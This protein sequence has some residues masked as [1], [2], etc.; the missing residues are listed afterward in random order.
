MNQSF[1]CAWHT[2]A[3]L[4]SVE[5]ASAVQ[6]KT[7]DNLVQAMLSHK[8][9]QGCKCVALF[10][11]DMPGSRKAFKKANLCN[12][13]MLETRARKARQLQRGAPD[14]GARSLCDPAVA[15]VRVYVT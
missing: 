4:Q 7:E 13:P 9:K 10:W 14:V 11:A 8:A 2:T 15:C 5:R 3:Q 1:Q 6:A 12:G